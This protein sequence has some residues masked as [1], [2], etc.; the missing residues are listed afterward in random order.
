M[1]L[2][3]VLDPRVGAAEEGGPSF[4]ALDLSILVQGAQGF[5]ALL[6][7]LLSRLWG[8]LTFC[9]LLS[10][11]SGA[12]CAVTHPLCS[13]IECRAPACDHSCVEVVV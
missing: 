1:V 8:L 5:R 10:E 9:S 4:T 12:P 11:D 3:L 13:S 7:L 2:Y 6:R